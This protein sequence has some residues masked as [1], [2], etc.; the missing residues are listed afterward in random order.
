MSNPGGVSISG[1]V[2]GGWLTGDLKRDF[3][4]HGK[5]DSI[6]HFGIDNLGR[7]LLIREMRVVWASA[8]AVP[9]YLAFPKMGD[10]PGGEMKITW[11]PQQST[12]L[13]PTTQPTAAYCAAR[14]TDFNGIGGWFNSR[15]PK[16]CEA[17][18]YKE[19]T[20]EC[21]LMDKEIEKTVGEVVNGF[22]YYRKV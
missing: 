21:Y 4:N 1:G 22:T 13:S 19:N 17:M 18:A 16:K 20:K 9:G 7:M 15:A 8:R 11:N 5:T 12:K 10:R 14:C 6:M 2:H 3:T